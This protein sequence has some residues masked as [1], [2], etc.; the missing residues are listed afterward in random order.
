MKTKKVLIPALLSFFALFFA[1][2]EITAGEPASRDSMPVII[3]PELRALD[4]FDLAKSYYSGEGVEQDFAA[5]AKL[6]R[7]VA[8]QGNPEAQVMMGF[9]HAEGKGVH[10]YT[11]CSETPKACE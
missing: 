3:D 6:Y 4:Q 2:R 10:L 9:L 5:A 1:F 11:I 8:E 7:E